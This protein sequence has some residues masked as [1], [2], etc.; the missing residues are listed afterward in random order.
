MQ[1]DDA[2]GV[3]RALLDEVDDDAGLL[4]RVQAH[5]PA[6]PLL[7]DAPARGRGEVHDTVARGEFQPS[8]SSIALMRMSISPRS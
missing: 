7:V 3:R 2:V 6:D 5:D 1:R 8:A 4:A